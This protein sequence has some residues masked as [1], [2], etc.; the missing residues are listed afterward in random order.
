MFSIIRFSN[1]NYTHYLHGENLNSFFI[2]STE[3]EEVISIISLLNGNK[4][5]GPSSVPARIFNTCS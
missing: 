5:S 1:K 2:T 3:S 4:S